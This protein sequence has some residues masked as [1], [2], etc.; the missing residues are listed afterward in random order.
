MLNEGIYEREETISVALLAALANQNT[1][2]LGPPGTA[3]S[4]VSRRLSHAFETTGYFEYLMQRFS[5]PEE[6]FGP[7][8]ISELKKDNYIR[9]TEGFLPTSDFSF[10][11]E[12]WKSSPAILNTLLTI[13]NEKIFKN[14]SE[15]T[16]VPLKSL[17]SASNETPPDN[18]GLEALYDR[19]L[20]RLFV[21]PI[22]EKENFESLLQFRPISVH[23]QFENDILIKNDEWEEWC[24]EIDNVKLSPETLSIIHHIRISFSEQLE[25][26]NLHVSDRRW[27]GAAKLLKAAAYF[28]SRKETNLVDSLLLRHCLWTTTENREEVI[29]IVE[30]AVRDCGFETDFSIHSID[31]QKEKLENEINHE[32]LYTY[33]TDVYDTVSLKDDKQY[34]K[35]KSVVNRRYSDEMEIGFYIPIEKMKTSKEFNPIDISGNKLLWIKCNFDQQGTCH[36]KIERTQNPN[37]YDWRRV[38]PFSPKVLFRKGERKKNVNDRLIKSLQKAVSDLK[39][40]IQNIIKQ[41]ENKKDDFDR[42]IY[43]PFV[44]K[45]IR[46]IALESVT[47][48][49]EDMKL[50]YKDC[51][52][53]MSLIG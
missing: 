14:G 6:V 39:N 28:C 1:F 31:V 33:T 36:I 23:A 51:D 50:R 41:I 4:M 10:L 52:R 48:Q 2:L 46:N 43:S 30:T 11:D 47:N 44:P 5:T 18:Q 20:V 15:I 37:N 13:I 25:E 26:L 53:V 32:L 27:K 21:P 29:K 45:K 40:D 35:C 19:F 24:N 22:E 49:L 42:Q 16:K 8:S 7:V 17:I 3:K 9:K 34:L 38:D 12:I